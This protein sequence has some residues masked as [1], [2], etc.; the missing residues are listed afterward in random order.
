MGLIA[1]LRRLIWGGQSGSFFEQNAAP[2]QVR[3]GGASQGTDRPSPPGAV[4]PAKK[5]RSPKT[6]APAR[7]PGK[8]VE[9]PKLKTQEELAAWL[10]ITPARLKWLAWP[11]SHSPHGVRKRSFG[12]PNRVQHYY[13]AVRAKPDGRKRYLGVPKRELKAVQRKILDGILRK[14]PVGDCAHGFCRGRSVLTNAREHVGHEIVIH[15]DL[16]HFFNSI[17]AKR[18]SGLFS[19]LGYPPPVATTLTLLCTYHV[20]PQVAAEFAKNYGRAVHRCLPQGAPT[21]PA[22]SN[23]ICCRLDV[24][25]SALARRFEARYT[26]YAD[27]LTFSG[28]DELLEGQKSFLTLARRIIREEGLFLAKNKLKIAR[29]GSRQSVTGIV[30]NRQPGVSRARR[31]KL[32]AILHRCS[33]GRPEE[34]NRLKHPNFKEYLQGWVSYVQMVNPQHGQNLQAAFDKVHW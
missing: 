11:R 5:A 28:D 18:V 10:G 4:P 24:R 23:L 21:S 31:R 7:P 16:A 1:W 12:P 22:I 2:G 26:R 14:L 17:N 25:L 3:A 34:Q 6:S 9:L 30:V 29:K 27:D 13:E 33:M 8:R 15:L 32:R 19:S 20:H